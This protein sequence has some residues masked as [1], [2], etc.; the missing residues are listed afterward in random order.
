DGGGVVRHILGKVSCRA[1]GVDEEFFGRKPDAG[2]YLVYM[3][4]ESGN[5][6]GLSAL[7]KR[8]TVEQN[9]TA[10]A[11]LK[12]LGIDFAFGFMLFEPS[13]TFQTV[14]QDLQFLRAIVGDGCT[15]ATFCRMV[16]YD[17]T[18]IKDELI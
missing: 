7:N 13:T 2:L 3:G 12:R 8:I 10:V 9:L 5:D 16:P 11:T 1:D 14:R 18:P 17:G 15:A 4:L 6:E